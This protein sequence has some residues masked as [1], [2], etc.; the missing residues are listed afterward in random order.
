[1]ITLIRILFNWLIIL[2]I[3]FSSAIFYLGYTV[4]QS[5]IEQMAVENNL[6]IYVKTPHDYPDGSRSVS[7]EFT[8]I[9]KLPVGAETS[10]TKNNLTEKI[11]RKLKKI[12]NERN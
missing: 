9:N 1:M 12:W 5:S 8:W 3:L 7:Y 2:L 10:K 4:G 6:G 11:S